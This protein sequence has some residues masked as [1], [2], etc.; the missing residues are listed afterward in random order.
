[1]ANIQSIS[2]LRNS[3]WP[4]KSIVSHE[5]LSEFGGNCDWDFDHLRHVDPDECC[6]LSDLGD[7]FGFAGTDD[8]DG[9]V[10]AYGFGAS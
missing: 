3:M 1:M 5:K 8:L 9:M 2:I 7:F 6:T 10:G 4:L